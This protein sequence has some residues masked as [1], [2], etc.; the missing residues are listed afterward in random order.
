MT[1]VIVSSHDTGSGTDGEV[2]LAAGANMSMRLWRN[3]EPPDKPP[4]RPR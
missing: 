3:E 4:H 2:Q 1:L